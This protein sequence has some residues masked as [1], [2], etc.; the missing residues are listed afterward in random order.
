[1]INPILKFNGT[2][3]LIE[4]MC[5]I[6]NYVKLYSDGKKLIGQIPNIF[7]GCIPDEDIISFITNAKYTGND[8][9]RLTLT[10]N[11]K[12][13]AYNKDIDVKV[14]STIKTVIPCKRTLKYKLIFDINNEN[15]HDNNNI[16][17]YNHSICLNSELEYDKSVFNFILPDIQCRYYEIL[18][19]NK[20]YINNIDTRTTTH[21]N[22]ISLP[23]EKILTISQIK[24]AKNISKFKF[25]IIGYY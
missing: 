14:Y 25:E 6:N 11:L 10:L 9:V 20:C 15:K 13:I 4:I 23:K 7:D 2:N 16:Y 19:Y 21:V 1:M 24:F 17:G 22:R 8:M 12:G 3:Y 5:K 18:F